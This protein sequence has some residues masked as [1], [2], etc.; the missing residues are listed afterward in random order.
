MS[1]IAG[2][3]FP[4]PKQFI[5]RL[6]VEKRNVLVKYTIRN[7]LSRLS[8]KNKVLFYV[9][10][11]SKEI[12][13][14]GIIQ[15]IH[16]LTPTQALQEY[17][18]KLFLNDDELEDYIHSQPNRD[19]S[20]QMLVLVLSNIEKYEKPKKFAKPITMA[21]LYFTKKEYKELLSPSVNL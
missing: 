2:I 10:Q 4:I 19:H 16:F 21:G 5:D 17:D 15:E 20:K 1:E 6:L 13:G 7:G 11:S 9:S 8:I 3:I 14:E 18:K 12:M